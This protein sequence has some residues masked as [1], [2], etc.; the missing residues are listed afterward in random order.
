MRYA[1]A[2][3]SIVQAR[4][5]AVYPANDSTSSVWTNVVV[6]FQSLAA[7][8]GVLL[9]VGPDRGGRGSL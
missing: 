5:R 9:W 1:R 4:T 6:G 7:S 2:T 3:T 8:F